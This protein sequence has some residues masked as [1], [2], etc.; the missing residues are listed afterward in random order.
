MVI[1]LLVSE[2]NHTLTLA[3]SRE[4][5]IWT[6][7]LEK[8]SESISVH[9]GEIRRRLSIIQTWCQV[10]ESDLITRPGGLHTIDQWDGKDEG[11]MIKPL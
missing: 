11:V 3:A 2:R 6:S 10:P 5:K 7:A 4:V 8:H 9:S 1:V